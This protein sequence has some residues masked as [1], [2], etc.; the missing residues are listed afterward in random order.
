[1]K[2]ELEEKVIT[3][4]PMR[5][6]SSNI[7]KERQRVKKE[8]IQSESVFSHGPAGKISRGNSAG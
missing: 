2:K 7:R 4:K 8:I 1:M 5:N 6:K 3:E